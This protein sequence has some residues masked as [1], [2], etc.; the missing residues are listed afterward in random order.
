M[1]RAQST[2]R[3]PTHSNAKATLPTTRSPQ[4]TGATP[5][6]PKRQVPLGGP[7]TTIA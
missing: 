6:T 5:F 4:S 7:T 3:E 2:I 1:E